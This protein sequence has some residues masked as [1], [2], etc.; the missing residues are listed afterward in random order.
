[1]GACGGVRLAGQVLRGCIAAG[2]FEIEIAGAR[3]AAS[4]SLAPMYDPKNARIR[5]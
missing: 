4:A 1:M 2:G 5:A 3:V